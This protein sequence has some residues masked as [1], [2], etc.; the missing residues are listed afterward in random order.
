MSLN[1]SDAHQH[2]KNEISAEG[3]PVHYSSTRPSETGVKTRNG[4]VLVPQPSDD[5]NDPLVTLASTTGY[6]H[7][8]I[9]FQ[10][11][12]QRKKYAILATLCMASFAGLA[13]SLANQL[14]FG[15]Q[16]KTYHKSLTQVSYTV[17]A[18]IAGIAFGP[19]LLNP[20]VHIV[21]CNSV[22]FWS[23]LAAAGCVVWGACMT[24][25]DQYE[26]FV[27][28]RL[29]CGLFGAAPSIF[30]VRPIIDMFFLHERG[31][32]FNTFHI[33]YLLGT[34]LGPTFSGFIVESKGWPWRNS[35]EGHPARLRFSSLPDR[36]LSGRPYDRRLWASLFWLVRC[37]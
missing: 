22:I 6:Y 26:P 32:A 33:C 14:A 24:D 1:T 17:S 13:L 34:V 9:P 8:L 29:F 28:S 27:A 25:E 4:I 30:G 7:V 36:T 35:T 37:K 20:L 19:L 21:G 18:A 2:V 15:A 23:L 31:R 16:A 12:S 10:N 11:W 3:E 5:P